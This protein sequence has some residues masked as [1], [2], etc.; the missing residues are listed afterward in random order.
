MVTHYA[1]LIKQDIGQ[2]ESTTHEEKV[3]IFTFSLSLQRSPVSVFVLK[4][5]N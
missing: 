4:G 3:H 5:K 2:S 1:E